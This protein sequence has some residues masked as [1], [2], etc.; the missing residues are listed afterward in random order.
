MAMSSPTVR[1]RE[2]GALL[3][4]LRAE[5]GLTVEQVADSLLCSPSKIS[6]LE[7]GQ[8]GASPRDIRDL[9]DLYRVTDPGQRKHLADLASEGRAQAWWQPFDLPYATYVGLEAE[10]ASIR[11]FAPGVFH[12]L[13]QIP[14]YTRAVHERGMPQLAPAVIEQRIEV[15]RGRQEILT[16]EDPPPPRLWAI[17]D[18]AVLHRPVGGP[19]V[20]AEQLGHVIEVC[21]LPNVTVQVIAYEAGAHP[22]LNSTFTLLDFA[23]P[24]PGVVHVEGLVGQLYFERSQDVQR[25]QEVFEWLSAIALDEQRSVELMAKM[26]AEFSHH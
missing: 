2:L 19:A 17:V 11:N 21:D 1:R 26:R 15:L 3:R 5:S 9:C 24:A 14:S 25:Y 12:G 8:R 23:G 22:A 18:E 4:A 7:T 10:A 16:R 6:R 20:M 13:L